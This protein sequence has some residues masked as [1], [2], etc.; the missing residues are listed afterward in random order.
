[1]LVPRFGRL[2]LALAGALCV[3]ALVFAVLNSIAYRG[4]VLCFDC[5]D[6]YALR[7]DCSRVYTLAGSVSDP[8]G[9]PIRGA[10][11][12]VRTAREVLESVSDASGRFRIMGAQTYC[13]VPIEQ[14]DLQI[15]AAG[16]RPLN[17]EAAFEV[18]E[19]SYA[20]QPAL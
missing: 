4:E 6:G 17:Q 19:G 10:E 14:V 15:A 12:Q 16:F 13:G 8:Y 2:I 5:G 20:L 1:V 3:V 18:Q 7:V 11:I 9:T